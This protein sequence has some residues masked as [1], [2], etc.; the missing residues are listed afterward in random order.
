MALS[1]CRVLM[2]PPWQLG[3]VRSL[4]TSGFLPTSMH[5]LYSNGP[6]AREAFWGSVGIA[7]P[8][9]PQ[10]Y[11]LKR[12]PGVDLNLQVKITSLHFSRFK[13]FSRFQDSNETF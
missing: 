1:T 10:A 3:A 8:G 4:Y 7:Q 6:K 11:R 5:E 13:A 12:V 9:Y 2:K